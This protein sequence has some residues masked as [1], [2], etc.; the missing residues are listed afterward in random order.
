MIVADVMEPGTAAVERDSTLA[1]A[2]TLMKKARRGFLPVTDGGAF[3]GVV[4]DM[5]LA[6]RAVCAC[7]DPCSAT[8]GEVMSAD[9]A[10]CGEAEGIEDAVALM[11]RW[12]MTAMLVV[13]RQGQPAGAVSLGRL[14]PHV[15]DRELAV[16]A[17]RALSTLRA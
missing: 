17:E 7:A 2:A 4:S 11:L 14:L 13:D 1:D 9:L 10:W 5:D 3:V 12:G 6:I 8:V 15:S 16:R